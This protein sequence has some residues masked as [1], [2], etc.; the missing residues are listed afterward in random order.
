MEAC[1]LRGL[2]KGLA[3]A[4]VAIE[5][6]NERVGRVVSWLSIVLVLNTCLVAVLRYG[7][8]LGWVWLQ[9][10]YLWT[11]ASI[12]L[13]ASGYTFLHDGHVRIDVFYGPASAR[14]KAWINAFGTIF[15]LFPTLF[16]IWWVSFPY[17]ELS[18]SR[19]EGSQQAGGLA[20]L[21]LLKSCILAFVILVGLQG[22]ALLLRSILVLQGAEEWGS[23]LKPLLEGGE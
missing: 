15:F 14:A 4:V 11:H 13:L 8:S 12:F 7:F 16:L 3:A 20:G 18:W 9:E 6:L 23:Q 10:V 2:M 22:V 5:R 21:F 17:V 19:L 1:W